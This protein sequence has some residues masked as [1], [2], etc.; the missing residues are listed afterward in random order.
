MQ[1]KIEITVENGLVCCFEDGDS[2]DVIDGLV[3]A[4]ARR[5]SSDRMPGVTNEALAE[6]VR[7]WVLEALKRDGAKKVGE[8]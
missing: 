1:T 6:G 8:K 2:Y 3:V 7:Q 4:L 5:I